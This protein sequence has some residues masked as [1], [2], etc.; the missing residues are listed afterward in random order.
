MPFKLLKVRILVWIGLLGIFAWW[1]SKAVIRYWNQPLT[2]DI[3]FT[4]GD[5]ENG[6]QFP[7]M[8]FCN[9]EFVSKN[10]VLQECMDASAW[11][12]FIDSLI[13]CL[14]NDK[15]FKITNLVIY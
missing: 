11:S 14:K 3:V 13:D 1:G 4:F 10:R 8:T 9:Y 12:F 2:T 7:L 6:I 15:N 5:N